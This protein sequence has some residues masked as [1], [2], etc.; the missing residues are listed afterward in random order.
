MPFAAFYIVPLE[1][2]IG[3]VYWVVMCRPTPVPPY[4]KFCKE[5]IFEGYGDEQTTVC[6]YKMDLWWRKVDRVMVNI[7]GEPAVGFVGVICQTRFEV[8][9]VGFFKKR[10]NHSVTVANCPPGGF[11][12]VYYYDENN[13]LTDW[14][15][16]WYSTPFVPIYA[17]EV[18]CTVIQKHGVYWRMKQLLPPIDEA[19]QTT[20]VAQAYMIGSGFVSRECDSKYRL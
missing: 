6:P 10:E 19:M 14:A 5:L 2:I 17:T 3:T 15:V 16:T 18:L 20:T 7:T 9:E 4:P 1:V 8:T 11:N 12:T 13:T